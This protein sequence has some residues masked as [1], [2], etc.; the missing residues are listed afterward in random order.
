[1]PEGSENVPA[2]TGP[3]GSN[4][5]NMSIASPSRFLPRV[6]IGDILNSWEEFADWKQRTSRLLWFYG[7]MGWKGQFV[8]LVKL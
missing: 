2:G 7:G 6:E 3:G 1:M 4:A 8:G 5:S